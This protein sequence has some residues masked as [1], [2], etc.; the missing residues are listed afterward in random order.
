MLGALVALEFLM[1]FSFLGYFH[2]EPISLTIA[3]VPV[4]LAGALSCLFTWTPG[5]NL[6]SSGW[7]IIIC[8]VAASALA[9]LRYPVAKEAQT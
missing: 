6:L 4:L 5:L 8:A 1:S 3:Y 2:V 9:A 7:V